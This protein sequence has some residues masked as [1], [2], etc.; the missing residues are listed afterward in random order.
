MF[1]NPFRKK[2][3]GEEGDPLAESVDFLTGDPTKDR[4]SLQLLLDAISEVA[5]TLEPSVLLQS[6][7][8]KS[9]EV[10]RSERGFLL[11]L[12]GEGEGELRVE[13][14]RDR[15]GHD[16]PLDTHYSQSVTQ[17]VLASG[18]PVA[19]VVQSSRE[20]LDLG[21][22]VYDL[23]LRSVMCVPLEG[24]SGVLGLIYV[25]SRA[26]GEGFKARDLHFFA[27]LAH[28][29]ALS[30]E[31]ARLFQA[32]LEKVRLEKELEFAQKI[33]ARLMPQPKGLPAGIQVAHWYQAVARASGDV[34]DV[35]VDP[36]GPVS[37]I[38]G[39]VTGHGIG[40]ALIA[41][42][43]QA[44]MHSYLEILEDLSEVVSR[45][46]HRFVAGL[47][48][49]TFMSL[50]LAR[51]EGEPGARRLSWVNAGHSGAWL[52]QKAGVRPLT[53]SSSVVG[54]DEGMSFPTEGPLPLEGGDLLFLCSDG[55]FEAR[56]AQ[57]DFLGEA[58][59]QEV[60]ESSHGLGAEALLRRVRDRLGGHI[61][62]TPLDDDV[63]LLGLSLED[64]PG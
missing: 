13:V 50:L 28:Q 35:I 60:L 17:K 9:L 12:E 27:A 10:T 39:D 14:A 64:L 59:V 62:R 55:L 33:Q 8:D 3:R 29:M 63:M 36:E 58:A 32:S 24:R 15:E 31:N 40:P 2:E 54:L 34:F 56:N 1:R 23:K 26:E 30:I 25:D 21:Q 51:I 46:N 48:A 47:E 7:V 22:S 52:V 43:V 53:N 41:H 44:A 37:V 61:G 16:L 57:G 20:A 38:L 6:L 4:R 11:L 19:S 45:M 42:S 18:E 5:T 49:G